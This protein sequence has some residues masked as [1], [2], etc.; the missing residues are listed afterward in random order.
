[1]GDWGDWG[2][3]GFPGDEGD[4]GVDGG[5]G[6]VGEDGSE[7]LPGV[8]GLKGAKGPQGVVGKITVDYFNTQSTVDTL[9]IYMYI[10]VCDPLAY[11]CITHSQQLCRLSNNTL[12]IKL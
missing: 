8:N 3:Q 12:N 2:D 6:L 11:Y 9:Y 7:G 4:V 10:D 1:M 5:P